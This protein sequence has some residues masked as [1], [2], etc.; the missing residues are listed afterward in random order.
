MEAG[1]VYHYTLPDAEATWTLLGSERGVCGLLYNEDQLG[2]ARAWLEKMR[3]GAQLRADR[4]PFEAFGAADRL[5]RYFAGERVGFED[6]PMDLM[7]TPFQREVWAALANIPYGEVWTY[8]RL[9]EE[10]GRPTATRAVGAANG[11]NPLPVI[12]PC[13]RVVGA[14]GTLTG[15]RG[16]LAVKKR[17]LA[18]EGIDHVEDRGHERFR[19]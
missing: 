11:R 14:N 1:T 18:L 10:I 19:F 2:E 12:L 9:A 3:P 16:G 17:L 7:G 8:G 15:Y 5:R 4:G 13:H 6:I